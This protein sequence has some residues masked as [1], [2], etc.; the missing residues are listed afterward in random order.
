MLH[1]RII[2]HWIRYD[3][4]IYN[5]DQ[6]VIPN[7]ADVNIYISQHTVASGNT[8]FVINIAPIQLE[9]HNWA[10]P[11]RKNYLYRIVE[12]K[13]FLLLLR[14]QKILDSLPPPPRNKRG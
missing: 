6:T 3:Y 11:F 8:H 4:C 7:P 14:N 1:S 10:L 13:Q 5:F 9:N 12:D 2:H